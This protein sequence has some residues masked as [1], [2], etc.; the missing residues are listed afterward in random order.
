MP[1]V[2]RGRFSKNIVI[3]S[4]Y[5]LLLWCIW[6]GGAFLSGY[7]FLVQKKWAGPP[8]FCSVAPSS[9]TLEEE[10]QFL[11]NQ[12]LTPCNNIPL[13][14]LGQPFSLYLFLAMVGLNIGTFWVI[15]RFFSYKT[16]GLTK[17]AR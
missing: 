13:V 2:H 4:T 3:T 10:I 15:F 14:V 9:H 17:N 7:H 1:F 11:T 5:L 12:P 8:G 6:A 16:K